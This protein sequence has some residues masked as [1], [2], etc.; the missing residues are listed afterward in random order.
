MTYAIP[1]QLR[2]TLPALVNALLPFGSWMVEKSKTYIPDTASFIPP[3]S[4]L[5]WRE[6]SVVLDADSLALLPGFEAWVSD[7]ATNEALTPR[8]LMLKENPTA[9]FSYPTTSVAAWRTSRGLSPQ[10]AFAPFS[11]PNP[12]MSYVLHRA[13]QASDPGDPVPRTRYYDTGFTLLQQAIAASGG[14]PAN[15]AAFAND[16]MND[17]N[18]AWPKSAAITSSAFIRRFTADLL[19]VCLGQKNPALVGRDPIWLRAVLIEAGENRHPSNEYGPI[20][21]AVAVEHMLD[22]L[23]SLPPAQ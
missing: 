7:D 4:A 19:I 9:F 21:T 8:W 18:D 2:P 6:K 1:A 16:L 17:T 15:W 11:G 23:A 22:N 10:A 12:N 3:V 14:T 13:N 5:P 20:Q